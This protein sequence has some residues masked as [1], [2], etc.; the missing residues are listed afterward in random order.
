MADDHKCTRDGEIETLKTNQKH[1][2]ERMKRVED[3]ADILYDLTSSVKVLS[4]EITAMREDTKEIKDELKIVNSDLM[5]FKT[6]GSNKWDKFIWW[7][8]I[9]GAGVIANIAIT[10]L[11]GM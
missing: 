5:T 3:K 11:G 10:N 7:A 1:I 6:A 8:F 9:F 2:F 4:T